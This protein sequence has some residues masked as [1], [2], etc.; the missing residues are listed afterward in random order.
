MAMVKPR[1]FCD[2]NNVIFFIILSTQKKLKKM[3]YS[4]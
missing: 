4:I 2:I 1:D 3:K